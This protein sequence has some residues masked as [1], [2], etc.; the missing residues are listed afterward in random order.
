LYDNRHC[1]CSRYAGI[2]IAEVNSGIGK[3]RIVDQALLNFEDRGAAL[4]LSG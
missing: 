2:R 1:T 4:L 3:I